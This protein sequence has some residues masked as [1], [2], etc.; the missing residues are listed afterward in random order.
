M[1][2]ISGSSLFVLKDLGSVEGFRRCEG[3]NVVVGG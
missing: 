3:F 1:K 2:Y